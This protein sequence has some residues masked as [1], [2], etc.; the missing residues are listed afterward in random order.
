M[1]RIK[2]LPLE[3]TRKGSMRFEDTG[4]YPDDVLL[5]IAR[6]FGIDGDVTPGNGVWDLKQRLETAG[7]MYVAA[8]HNTA[9][10]QPRDV[11]AYFQTLI[12]QADDL[13]EL[14]ERVDEI[15]WQYIWQTENSL[16]M[17]AMYKGDNRLFDV[18]VMRRVNPDDSRELEYTDLA[19]VPNHLR[20]VKLLAS[21][22]LEKVREAPA[23][24][25][26]NQALHM[27]VYAMASHWER[28]M[29]REF[30]VSYHQNVPTSQAGQFLEVCL[31]PMDVA[32]LPELVSQMRQVL[33]DRKNRLK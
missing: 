11:R 22:C 10:P 26:K 21:E 1:P 6:Q 23:G 29:G 20:Y 13:L 9:G 30:T 14:L 33:K 12:E 24:R 2:N 27:W 25:K 18:G 15:S 28:K 16:Q 4:F 3:W 5:D 19:E 8:K 7:T 31:R 17:D 32:A